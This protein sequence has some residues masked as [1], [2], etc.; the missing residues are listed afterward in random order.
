MDIYKKILL[1]TTLSAVSLTALYF[2]AL[3]LLPEF[4]DLN[5]Y[6]EN[7]FEAIK[8]ETGY[9]VSSENIY[10]E[11]NINPFLNIHLYH[12]AI[13]YPNDEVFIQIKDAE[14]KVKLLPLLFKQIIIKDAKFS[15][16]IINIT[17]YKDFSTSL[18]KYSV[19]NKV[20][21]TKGFNFNS[22]ANDTSFKNYKIKFKDETISKTF[23]LEGDELLLKDI[24]LNDKAHIIVKGSIYENKT[25]YIKYDMELFPSLIAQEHQFTFSPFKTIMDSN[26][27]GEIKGSLRID[28]DNNINGNLKVDNLSL[29]LSNVVS[30][31]NSAD[32]LFKGNEAFVNAVLHTS[33]TDIAKVK[34]MFG[35]GKKRYI[36]LNTNAKNI[37]LEN[38]YKIV[39]SVSKIL[40]IQNPLNDINLTGILNADFSLTSDFKKLKSS[41]TA[42][43]KDA[44]INHK[45]LPY[46]I[47]DINATVNFNNNMI[48]IEQAKASVNNTPVCIEGEVN[49]ELNADI[50]AYSDNLDLR[51]IVVAFFNPSK[52]PFDIKNGKVKF[53]S[54]IKGNLGKTIETVSDININDA[55]FEDKNTKTPLTAK[56]LNINLKTNDKKYSGDII[57]EKLKTEIG[58]YS[59]SSDKFSFSFDDKFINI[60]ENVLNILSSSLSIKGNIKD[61]STN[62]IYNIDF[63]S[64]FKASDIASVLKQYISLPYK[65]VGK[66][67]ITGKLVSSKNSHNIKSQIKADKNNYLSYAVIKEILDKP[68][69]INIDCDVNKDIVTVKDITLYDSSTDT[70][71]NKIIF[72]NGEVKLA[73]EPEFKN[74]KI[75]IPNPIS[76]KMNLLGGEDI[77][78]TS[79]I[80][81][82]KSL[83][84]PKITG[85]MLVKQYNIKKY[86]TAVKNADI[87]FNEDNIRVLAPNVQVNDSFFNI[88]ADVQPEL[89]PNN[90]TVNN[91][92]INS[93]K[94]DLNS[95]FSFLYNNRELFAKSVLNIKHG[96][97][98]I[99]DFNILD[100][101]ARDIS[102]DFKVEKNVIKLSNI[103]AGSY[104]GFI[105]GKAD[106]DLHSGFLNLDMSGKGVDIKNSLYDLC[107][108]DDNLIGKADFNVRVSMLTGNYNSVIKSL[109]GTMKF[110][111]QNGG[112]GTLGKFEYYLSAKNLMYHGLLNATIN[113]IAE[114][115][116]HDKTEQYK[117]AKGNILFQNGYI[118]TDGIQTT[119]TK[120]SLYIIGRHNILTNQSN[121]DIYGRVSDDITK[122]VGTA[123]NISLAELFS[124]QSAKKD[125]MLTDVPKN[126]TDKI[127]ELYNAN[128][129]SN[130]FKV[131]ILGDIKAINSI[132]Y[133][134]WISPYDDGS[135]QN[136]EEIQELIEDSEE[137]TENVQENLPEFSDMIQ[138][139]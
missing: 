12:T 7:V 31:E 91:M 2:G 29:K 16:P 73:K 27:K 116:T 44:M 89:S 23:Y 120:T 28:K 85:S 130:T 78:L 126:I 61:Y 122:K 133:F 117:T 124:G 57:F 97:A 108:F 80:I 100:M 139:I 58:K 82:N 76:A 99:N 93:I 13:L 115:L 18:E 77:S 95:L 52:I 87:S 67:K 112:M 132:N 125:V 1:C 137:E 32:I 20:I 62:P 49:Q 88:I 66:V 135:I 50:K 47:K 129:P 83:N 9:K 10:F 6:K 37:N 43:L 72:A 48:K 4:V 118:I 41:G 86:L 102:S 54:E 104:G 90:I 107:K 24:Q 26:V 42:L 35:F 36:E 64:D 128:T 21:N 92:Q 111:A 33:K 131:N 53:N 81:I 113:R 59:V 134:E 127:P 55:F 30:S 79:D 22:I 96:V 74:L 98:T 51:T 105:E 71:K 106:Y 8:N 40:N 14:L 5:K 69:V 34:G 17:L 63:N 19:Q 3:T 68:S 109:N 39:S 114:A 110:N 75:Q 45:E 84:K 25:E 119:G 103:T 11:K 94:L 70:L 101:K 136:N 60:P 65:A 15:R 123:G 138:D 121:I 56:V 46:P 38:L